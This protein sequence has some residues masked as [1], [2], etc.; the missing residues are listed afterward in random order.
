MT[1]RVDLTTKS[2][3]FSIDCFLLLASCRSEGEPP[4]VEKTS[5]LED[6]KVNRRLVRKSICCRNS[7]FSW[8]TCKM[9]L[10]T[11]FTS[12]ANRMPL[13]CLYTRGGGDE[14]GYNEEEGRGVILTMSASFCCKRCLASSISCSNCSS[15]PL[16]LLLLLLWSAVSNVLAEEARVLWRYDA[17]R[18]LMTGR[19]GSIY[20]LII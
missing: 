6:S 9:R 2:S 20:Y 15:L 5:D 12:S 8:F 19:E 16:P 4:I 7:A 14:T 18:V 13:S 17:E 10:S 3:S 11:F 1:S